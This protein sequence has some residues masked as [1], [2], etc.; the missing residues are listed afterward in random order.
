[1]NQLSLTDGGFRRDQALKQTADQAQSW[2]VKT[3]S[4][5]SPPESKQLYEKMGRYLQKK[6]LV[7]PLCLALVNIDPERD[8]FA[9]K[10]LIGDVVSRQG[11]KISFK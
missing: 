1:M 4:E 6:G 2:R 8:G 9:E 11:M 5:V 10:H 3:L 7:E